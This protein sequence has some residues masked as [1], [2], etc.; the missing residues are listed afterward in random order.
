VCVLSLTI[1]SDIKVN[2][3]IVDQLRSLKIVFRLGVF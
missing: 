3:L 2:V 1:F